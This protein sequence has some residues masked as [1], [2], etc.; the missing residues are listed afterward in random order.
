MSPNKFNK[1]KL[2]KKKLCVIQVEFASAPVRII[3]DEN[4]PNPHFIEH[5]QD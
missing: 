1:I 4:K 5:Y 2:K 3:T